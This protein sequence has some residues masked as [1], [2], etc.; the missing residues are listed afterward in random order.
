MSGKVNK[1]NVMIRHRLLAAALSL[2]FMFPGLALNAKKIKSI[3]FFKDGKA[4]VVQ[5]SLEPGDQIIPAG[6]KI[7]LMI[8][9]TDRE[10]TLWREPGTV[11][12]V[13]LNVSTMELPVVGGKE[14]Y[15]KATD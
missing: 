4:P 7:A 13:D 15:Q 14:A 1:E 5:F 9:S 2:S 8:F 6:K 12:T 3:P 11:I 10:F